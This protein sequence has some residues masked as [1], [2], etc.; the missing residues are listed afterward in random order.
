[1]TTSMHG[2]NGTSQ[3]NSLMSAPPTADL[4]DLPQ[5]V[6][7]AV[8]GAGLAG[9]T[10]AATAARAGCSVALF[11]QAGTPGGRART[12]NDD[13]FAFNIGP[14]ALYKDGL[15]L[16]ILADLEVTVRA[17]AVGLG[18]AQIE[19]DGRLYQL[20]ANLRT[21]LTSR[22]LDWR[23][24]LEL[25][26]FL[27]GIGKLDPAPLMG[28]PLEAWLAS[29]IRSPMARQLVAVSI[30]TAT[31]ADDPGRLSAGAG[32]RQLKAGLSGA[33]YVHGGWQTIVD[34][35]RS[36]AEVLGVTVVSGARVADV[37]LDPSARAAAGVRLANGQRV[38]AGTVILAV[39]P[40][41]ASGLVQGGQQPALAGWAERAVPVRAASLDIG[42]RRLPRPHDWF[43]LGFERPLYLSV[44]SNW[45]RLAPDGRA[46]VHVLK[47]LGPS[48]RGAGDEQELEGLLDLVQ[49]G[50]RAEVVTRR[51][52]PETVVAG[53]LPSVAWETAEGPR[54]PAVPGLDGLLVAGDW[55]G[56][57]GMLADR[58]VS[59]GA[60]AG[61]EA[62]SLPICAR[63]GA[64]A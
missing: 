6:D 23:A 17:A 52:L 35:L 50:W 47:Y 13:G 43:A 30:R 21:L 44:H 20:P 4:P 51:F 62:A 37:E 34:D 38:Q 42:L 53:A 40:M 22:L 7:V 1:M 54:G 33:L 24:R 31:Y 12:R 19:R 39:P 18:G 11:E 27:G 14:H 10:A 46:L 41:A 2:T 8:V 29:A 3:H 32:L 5:R 57:E 64:V 36:R 63:M 15:T 60:R 28:Q 59:S 56:P 48:P 16:Q 58:A 25:A 55:V 45:A 9:L 49:P 26:T 61:V